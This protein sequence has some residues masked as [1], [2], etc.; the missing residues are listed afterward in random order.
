MGRF[1]AHELTFG[2]DYYR[3]DLED[4]ARTETPFGVSDAVT[5]PT[6]YQTGVG[7][8]VQDSIEATDDLRV[9]LGVRGDQFDFVSE[10]DPRYEGE[11]FDVTDSDVSGNVGVVYS[12]TPNVQLT[13]LVGRGFRAPNIQE[14]AY[15]GAVSEPGYLLIQNPDLDSERTLNYEAGFK[16]RYDRYF[17]GLTVFYND[18]EDLITFVELGPDPVS[19]LELLQYDNIDEATIR[20]VELELETLF[21]RHWRLFTTYAYTRGDNE[22]TG[23][24]LDFIPPWKLVLGVRYEKPGWWVELRGRMA[25]EQTRIPGFEDISDPEEERQPVGDFAVADLRGGFTLD[26]GM[27]VRATLANLTNELYSEPFNLRPEPARNL[28]VSV[29]YAF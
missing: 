9:L 5:V 15:S 16:I 27:S 6:S 18:V 2:L 12:L 28:R 21:A 4:E 17:G 20:G 14:R 11:P 8:Y 26:W 7:V 1:G 24:P 3:D 10:D 13:G 22:L 23:E 19:G 29:G 25:G